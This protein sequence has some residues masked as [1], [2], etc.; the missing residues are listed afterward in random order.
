MGGGQMPPQNLDPTTEVAD[1]NS[2]TSFSP[3]T[4]CVVNG[5]PKSAIY[6]RRTRQE[7]LRVRHRPATAIATTNPPSGSAR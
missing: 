6:Y 2:E 5:A 1:V 3:V 7:G 4:V